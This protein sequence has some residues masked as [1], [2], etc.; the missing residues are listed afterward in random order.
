MNCSEIPSQTYPDPTAELLLYS[1][2]NFWVF[3]MKCKSAYFSFEQIML[4]FFE[5]PY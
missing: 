3:L 1:K 4:N 5:P 2:L